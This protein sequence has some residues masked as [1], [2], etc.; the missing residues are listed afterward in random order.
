[1]KQRRKT[2]KT[3]S[4]SQLLHEFDPI[5]LNGALRGL[6]SSVGWKVFQA[7]TRIKQREFEIAALD[8]VRSNSH[9]HAAAHSSG[10]A[11]ALD[12]M[13]NKFLE[14]LNDLVLGKNQVT[15]NPPPEEANI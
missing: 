12:D 3:P 11:Q 6:E 7:Y 13:A 10:Y 5:Q 9:T 15:E 1:M 4:L 14:A 8:L 2:A